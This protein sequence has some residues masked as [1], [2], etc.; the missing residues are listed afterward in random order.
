[1]TN[2]SSLHVACDA[3]ISLSHCL[4]LLS[5][6]LFGLSSRSRSS[7]PEEANC[8]ILQK[9]SPS[10]NTPKVA[11]GYIVVLI[12]KLPQNGSLEVC[13]KIGSGSYLSASIE[14]ETL[15]RTVRVLQY[16]R[17]IVATLTTTSFTWSLASLAE[18]S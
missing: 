18:H 11:G 4:P 16:R 14:S 5:L 6:M 3:S 10:I 13:R 9:D 12:A 1:M 7:P 2:L 17:R 8:N 15:F